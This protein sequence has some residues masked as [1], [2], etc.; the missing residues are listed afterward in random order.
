MEFLGVTFP[1]QFIAALIG[2]SII[3][4][5]VYLFINKS[6]M[7]KSI[8][9]V[10]Q[11]REAAKLM[12]INVDRIL[13]ITLMISAL[14]AGFAAVLYAPANYIAPHIGWTFLLSA[15]AVTV[16]GGMGSILGSIIGAYIMAYASNLGRYFINLF[17]DPLGYAFSVILPF[18]VILVMLVVRPQGLLGKKEIK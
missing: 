9:A 15:F 17:F 7:G 3:V 16:F 18:V 1:A 2:S 14:L 6:K 4:V 5:M 12:G 10:S 8:R 11:D 13:M